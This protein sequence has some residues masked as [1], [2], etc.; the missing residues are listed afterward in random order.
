MKDR[1][2]ADQACLRDLKTSDPRE[3]KDRIEEIKGGLLKDAF[4]WVLD[5]DEFN[6]WRKDEGKR[7]L[8]IKGN[9]GKGKTMLLCGLLDEMP[10]LDT[11]SELAFVFCQANN[12]HMND[13]TA[14]L[15]GIIYM[16]VTQKPALLHHVGAEYDKSGKDLFEGINGWWALVKIFTSI[17]EQ[18]PKACIVVDALDECT[19]NLTHLLDLISSKTAIFPR[20]KWIVS[21][22]PWPVIEERL[23][24]EPRKSVLSLEDNDKPIS[25]AVAKY[26][27]YKVSELA[28]LKGHDSTT[29]EAIRTRLLS[30]AEGT[31]LWVALVFEDLANAEPWNVVQVLDSLPQGLDA[32][33]RRMVNKI[34][35]SK[36]SKLYKQILSVILTV[37]RPIN[38]DEV[39]H[40]AD[41][42]ET[43]SQAYSIAIIESCGSFLVIRRGTIFFVHQSAPEYLLQNAR[44]EI[45][46]T[47]VEFTHSMIARQS[48]RTLS[49][50]LKRDMYDIKD[51]GCL[52]DDIKKPEPDPLT[53]V[54]YA[55]IAWVDHLEAAL[56][57]DSNDASDS[58]SFF[59]SEGLVAEFLSHKY[60]TWLE[61]LSI[62]GSVFEG[63]SAMLKLE[64]LLKVSLTFN[65]SNGSEPL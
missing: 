25:S 29:Q 37:Y 34:N 57:V 50:E 21:S 49:K 65:T 5:N 6:D 43:R 35:D 26:V 30:G 27:G 40:L 44:D 23:K 52:I 51:P 39:F 3:D 22:R 47:G 62:L 32:L 33:Y 15:R 18:L 45:L 31:F 28:K 16:L 54:R 9:P 1:Q 20:V 12:A 24:N 63:I 64:G 10:K 55:C 56:A 42:F 11:E 19:S 48:L 61:A 46:S 14:V 4:Q 41:L 17:L 60:L 59:G 7:I 38:I 58:N 13:A 36:D 53:P 2:R 8:W